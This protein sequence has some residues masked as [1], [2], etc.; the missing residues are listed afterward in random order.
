[1]LLND[2][3]EC[4]YQFRS[5]RRNVPTLHGSLITSGLDVLLLHLL[6]GNLLLLGL[7]L[8]A[9]G[10]LFLDQTDLDVAGAAHVG[11]DP[12]VSSVCPPPHLGSTVDLNN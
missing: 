12:S 5:N 8:L 2:R 1:M 4:I 10:L 9:K 7:I 3:H 11:I 6:L